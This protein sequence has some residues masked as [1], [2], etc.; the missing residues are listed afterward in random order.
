[1]HNDNGSLTTASCH[2]AIYGNAACK[3]FTIHVTRSP[4]LARRTTGGGGGG[5][6]LARAGA[7]VLECG[8]LLGLP[9]SAPVVATD[10][11]GLTGAVVAGAAALSVCETRL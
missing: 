11:G 7:C 8:V 9:P 6:S 2:G 5:G 3:C 1:M 4:T 10:G